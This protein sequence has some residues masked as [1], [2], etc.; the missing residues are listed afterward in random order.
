MYKEEHLIYVKFGSRINNKHCV[1]L[2]EIYTQ[3]YKELMSDR[4]PMDMKRD[5][6]NNGPR[7]TIVVI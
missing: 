4:L 1:C 2:F 6:A 5:P 7:A 3:S